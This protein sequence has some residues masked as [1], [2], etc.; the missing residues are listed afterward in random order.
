MFQK[1]QQ[2]EF[3]EH[4]AL[5]NIQSEFEYSEYILFIATAYLLMLKGRTF[6]FCFDYGKFSEC[7][8]LRRPKN[9]R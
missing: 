1:P 8:E 7:F 2:H 9:D 3:I 5:F 6:R 4:K